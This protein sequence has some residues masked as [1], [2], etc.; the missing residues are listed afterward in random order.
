[1]KKI[2]ILIVSLI[3]VLVLGITVFA[4]LYFATDTFK[5]DKDIFYKYAKQIEL[6]E[7]IDLEEYNNYMKRIESEGHGSEGEISIGI[8]QGEQSIKETIKYSR[9]F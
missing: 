7:F 3:A 1:M 8:T 2:Q 9:I 4:A 6:K 5:S